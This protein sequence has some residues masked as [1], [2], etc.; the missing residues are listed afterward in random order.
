MQIFVR[1]PTG[2]MIC[3]RVQPSHTLYA[4]KQKILE[5]HHLAFDGV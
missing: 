5:H 1:S 3:L 2:R 4:V